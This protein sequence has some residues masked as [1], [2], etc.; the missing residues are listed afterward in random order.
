M[1]SSS[2]GL[3]YLC[4]PGAHSIH[5][6]DHEHRPVF[7]FGGFGSRPGQFNR[8]TDVAVVRIDGLDPAGPTSV[9]TMLVV[10]DRGNHRLQLFELDGAS[11]AV[12]GGHAGAWSPGRWPARTG[13]PFFCLGC[14]PR[15]PFPS[16]LEWRSPYLDVACA[17]R[18]M[19]RLD[20]A[21]ALLPDFDAWI[22]EASLAELGQAF[23]WFTAG[24]E[25]AEIP[26]SC[27]CNMMERLAPVPSDVA[28]WSRRGRG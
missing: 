6:L 17:G 20:L 11:I 1:N 9:P 21:A 13:W 23:R 28:A 26:D 25:R 16:R 14:V 18:M 19:V 10:A 2:G 3:V 24:P 15:L 4:D 12:I 7:S 22:A 8:P 27:L 5:L